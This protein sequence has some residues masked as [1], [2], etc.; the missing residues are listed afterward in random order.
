MKQI[1]NLEQPKPNI[2][3]KITIPKTHKRLALIDLDETLVHCV[4]KISDDC[5]DYQH[6]VEVTLPLGK[7]VKIGINIRPHL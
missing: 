3:K 1:L 2:L 4:G 5:E 6:E 7:K